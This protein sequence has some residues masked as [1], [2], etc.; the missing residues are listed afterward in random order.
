MSTK[1]KICS[2][3]ADC[4]Q[5]NRYKTK[6]WALPPCVITKSE[7]RLQNE[8]SQLRLRSSLSEIEPLKRDIQYVFASSPTTQ[9]YFNWKLISKPENQYFLVTSTLNLPPLVHLSGCHICHLFHKSCCGHLFMFVPKLA[10]S[11][12]LILPFFVFPLTHL[13]LYLQSL[14][15]LPLSLCVNREACLNFL[16]RRAAT[17]HFDDFAVK[18]DI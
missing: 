12:S 14:L 10:Y 5:M 4:R 16:Q 7:I 2:K 6:T 3:P 18:A 15:S 8:S 9:L 1:I 13:H 11:S 17:P